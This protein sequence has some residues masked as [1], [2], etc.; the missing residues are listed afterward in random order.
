MAAVY[1]QLSKSGKTDGARTPEDKKTRQRVLML[2]SRGVTHRHRHLMNDLYALLPHSRKDAKLDTKTKLYQLNELA[3]LYN[4]NNVLFFEARKGKDLYVWMSKA[5]NGP[6]IKMH[7]YNLNTSAELHFTGNCLKGS[8]PILSFSSAFDTDPHLRV[9]KELF[10]HIFGVPKSSRKTKPFVDHVMGFTV[11][12]NKV[13]IRVFQIGEAEQTKVD[14][15]AA[16]AA[17]I[18]SGSDKEKKSKAKT[19]ET[20][21]SLIEIGPR[22]VLTPIVI[23]QGSFGGPVIYENK[24]FVS[25]NQV[26]SELRLGKAAKLRRR[27]QQA[28]EKTLKRGELGLNTDG[29]KKKPRDALDN[30]VLFA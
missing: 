7:L 6:T 25:P 30:R 11:H 28:T 26:R 12:D 10:S 3:E 29:G 27:T 17:A 20:D 24:E 1:K 23:L 4:C 16:K 14:K 22:F 2:S 19:D 13:W 21:I 8:R 18:A 9:L 15:A 5:P